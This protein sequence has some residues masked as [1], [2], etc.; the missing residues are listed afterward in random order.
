MIRV[1]EYA[2]FYSRSTPARCAVAGAGV[3]PF[4]LK[5]ISLPHRIAGV[6]SKILPQRSRSRA[7]YRSLMFEKRLLRDGYASHG[8]KDG[9]RLTGALSAF[10]LASQLIGSRGDLFVCCAGRYWI[11]AARFLRNLWLA[12]HC[13]GH[14]WR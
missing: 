14:G 8:D 9:K 5:G 11:I 12:S 7:P 13:A 10:R 4:F 3:M 2:C 1:R 6:T